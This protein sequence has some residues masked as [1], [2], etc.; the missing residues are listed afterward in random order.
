MSEYANIIK[1][2]RKTLSDANLITYRH[3]KKIIDKHFK[4]HKQDMKDF[5]DKVILDR[6]GGFKA[7]DYF[8]NNHEIMVIF[9]DK[10]F[11]IDLGIGSLYEEYHYIKKNGEC[12]VWDLNSIIGN[13]FRDTVIEICNELG[14]T[15]VKI[16]YYYK[17]IYVGITC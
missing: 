15:P 12:S 10:F 9:D 13:K 2:T 14:I 11:K 1:E 17:R 7:R 4:D 6:L 3:Y 8:R 5:I 16:E